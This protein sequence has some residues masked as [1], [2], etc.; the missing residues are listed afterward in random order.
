MSLG[1][2]VRKDNDATEPTAKNGTPTKLCSACGKKSDA[3]QKCR[4]CKCVWYCDKDCQNRHWKEHKK[5]CKRIMKELDK[6]GGKLDLGNE[7]DLGTLPVLPPQEECPICMRAL[8]LNTPLQN[9]ASCCGKT[10]CAGCNFQH[11]FQARK[12]NAERAQMQQPPV[13]RTCAFCR[14]PFSKADEELVAQRRKRV[15]YNDPCA[16]HNLALDHGFGRHG[17]PVDQAKC[18]DLLRQSAGL[19]FPPAQYQLGAF[20]YTGDMGLEQSEEEAI[21]CWEKAAEGGDVHALHNLGC[22]EHDNGDNVAAMHHW[23]LSA[24]EGFRFSMGRLIECFEK[25]LL[26]HG[27]LAETIQAMYYARAEL[28]SEDRDKYIEHLKMRGEYDEGFDV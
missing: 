20:H 26:H 19:D 17:L 14:A 18:I 5:E 27:E 28:K 9:Y 6:R 21:K 3:L 23:R 25:G 22:I 2:P 16:M 11:E 24:S 8:P 13:P 1:E 4:A 10:F 12:V 7:V 15:K